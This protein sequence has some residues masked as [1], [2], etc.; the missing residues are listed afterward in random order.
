MINIIDKVNCCGCSACANAC[1]KNCITMTEDSEGFL[2]PAV[3]KQ[4]CINCGLCEKV[5]PIINVQQEATKQ[6]TAYLIQNNDEQVL[7]ESTSGGAF[8]AFA[9]VIVENGGVVFGAALDDKLEVRHICVDREEDLHKFRNS[10]Y[11]Q[12]VLG[13]CFQQAKSFLD[14]GRQVL[15]SGT[16]CQIEGLKSFL[17]K[18]YDSLFTVDV[19]CHAYPSPLIWRK[20]IEFRSG[21]N[22]NFIDA[23][24]RDKADYGYDYS[25]ISLTDGSK[26]QHYG[27][28]SDPY[29]RAF[30][31][32]LSD[33][34]SCYNCAFKKRYRVSDV[35]IWDC[36]DVYKFDKEFDDNRGVT[37]VLVHSPKGGYLIEQVK[38][39]CKVKQIDTEK[40]VEGV[41]EMVK[42]VPSNP[43]REQFF[44]DAAIMESATFFKKWFPDTL[45]VKIERFI[46]CT[47]E[48]LGIYAPV[49]RLA[50]KVLR[51]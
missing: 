14:S 11:V 20:Y 43:N 15:F 7:K 31:S 4:L 47:T 30:F 19:V 51:K 12:S 41:R 26:R 18:D 28:E 32:N 27:V 2:Y 49:K 46:R 25:Q 21:G 48:K 8:T 29:L 36:F 33:R 9:Q 37:R 40:A 23:K 34:P 24:F 6:Q 50:K 1:P 44:A 13:D 42:S 17:R 39:R 22:G 16:P 35:T 45:K 5:C 3:D 10:K 38:I